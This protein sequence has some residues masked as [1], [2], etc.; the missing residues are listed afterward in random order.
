MDQVPAIAVHALVGPN[1]RLLVKPG[2]PTADGLPRF[3]LSAMP[4]VLRKLV[5]SA[6]AATVRSAAAALFLPLQP[7]VG[8][9]NASERNPSQA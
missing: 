5:S 9:P 8:T 1:L 6:L 2:G 3:R 4:E 7:G